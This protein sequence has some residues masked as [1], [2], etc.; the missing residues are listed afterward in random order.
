MRGK[1]PGSDGP[2]NRPP[3]SRPLRRVLVIV[4]IVVIAAILVVVAIYA[5]A[6]IMLAP[7]MQ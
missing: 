6:F 5:A 7:M 3:A 1:A 4:G 2:T